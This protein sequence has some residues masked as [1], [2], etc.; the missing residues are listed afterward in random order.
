MTGEIA[1]NEPRGSDTRCNV[2]IAWASRKHARAFL[3]SGLARSSGAWTWTNT[4]NARPLTVAP[5]REEGTAALL[6]IL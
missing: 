3:R 1:W 5:I 4:A 2:P 6:S